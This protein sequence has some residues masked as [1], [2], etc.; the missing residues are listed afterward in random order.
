MD[1]LGHSTHT[2]TSFNDIF[3]AYVLTHRRI[4][5]VGQ[6][7]TRIGFGNTR[8]ENDMR[9]RLK[10]GDIVHLEDGDYVCDLVNDSRA[11]C[12]PLVKRKAA[13]VDGRTGTPIEFEAEG[14]SISIG[15]EIEE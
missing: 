8:G 1:I 4:G 3:V 5:V 6:T 9:R 11:R 12:R 14:R 2:V 10:V 7:N 13:F 15:T